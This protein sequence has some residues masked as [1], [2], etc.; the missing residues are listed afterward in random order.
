M[1]VFRP[2][3]NFIYLSLQTKLKAYLHGAGNGVQV[4]SEKGFFLR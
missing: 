4:V 1:Q 3:R 2:I